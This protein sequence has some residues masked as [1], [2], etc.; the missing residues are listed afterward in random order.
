VFETPG[1]H[2]HYILIPT[3][4]HSTFTYAL[5]RSN[6]KNNNDCL[7]HLLLVSISSTYLRAAFMPVAPQSVR[8]QSSCQYL[9]TLLGS[10]RVKDVR[11][12]LMKLSPVVDVRWSCC[13]YV[14]LKIQKYPLIIET[15]LHLENTGFVN[16]ISR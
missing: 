13:V 6:K 16:I 4:L 9:F 14:P 5:N 3:Y 1:L 12:T 10:T 15:K 2:C 8:T 7:L 11:R